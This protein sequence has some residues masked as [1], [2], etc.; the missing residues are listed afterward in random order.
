MQRRPGITLALTCLA[1]VTPG[2]QTGSTAEKQALASQGT[3][4]A[5]AEAIKKCVQADYASLAAL[6]KHFHS[7]PELSYQ[8]EQTAAR[9]AHEL[10]AA[11]FEVTTGVGGHGVVGVLR[12]GKGPTVLV[13]TDMDALPVTEATGLP[14]ASKVRGRSAEG[15]EVGVMHACGH[16][17]K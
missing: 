4:A 5:R 8:E 14:Y 12:N 13:R 2:L 1:A 15:R 16:D 11:G 10:K 7:H 3:G 6:Y 9:L 17:M